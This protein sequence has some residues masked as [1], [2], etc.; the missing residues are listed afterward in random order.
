[1]V[2]STHHRDDSATE[3]AL[4]FLKDLE[5]LGLS[6]IDSDVRS[7]LFLIVHSIGVSNV[8]DHQRWSYCMY[9]DEG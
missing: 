5:W 8:Y 3:L 7:S 2:L 9:I 1:M 6:R 4:Q